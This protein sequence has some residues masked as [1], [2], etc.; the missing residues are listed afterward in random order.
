VITAANWR[1]N[2]KYLCSAIN[3]Y[4]VRTIF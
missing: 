3:L 4:C 2:T 1:V